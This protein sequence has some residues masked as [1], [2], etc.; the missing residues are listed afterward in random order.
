MSNDR[1]QHLLA[2]LSHSMSTTCSEPSLMIKAPGFEESSVH[3]GTHQCEQQKKTVL[4]IKSIHPSEAASS[5]RSLAQGNLSGIQTHDLPAHRGKSLTTRPPLAPAS[6][7]AFCARACCGMFCY[8]QS[9]LQQV[10]LPLLLA[11]SHGG[12]I[13]KP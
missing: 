10:K 6:N 8:L 11:Q 3:T 9:Y 2:S 12:S 7:A 13:F 5:V 1:V 4:C